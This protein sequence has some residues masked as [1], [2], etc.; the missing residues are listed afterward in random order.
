M[1]IKHS[2]RDN[3]WRD[4]DGWGAGIGGIFWSQESGFRNGGG[5][6]MSCAS[7]HRTRVQYSTLV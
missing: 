4:N 3:V 2:G 6:M 1:M 7:F 5:R